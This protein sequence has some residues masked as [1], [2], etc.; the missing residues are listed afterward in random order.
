MYGT[1]HNPRF[2]GGAGNTPVITLNADYIQI[3]NFYLK[4]S[5]SPNGILYITTGHHDITLNNVAFGAGIRGINAVKMGTGGVVNL[6]VSHCWFFDIFD[7][8]KTGGNAGAGGAGDTA[9]GGGSHIQMNNCNGSGIEIANSKFYTKD[10]SGANNNNYGVGD[11]I[12]TFQCNGTAASR[13]WIHDNQIRGG[14]N[15]QV[16]GYIGITT[17][18]VGGSYQLVENNILVNPGQG[19]IG[20][21]PSGATFITIQNNRMYSKN[22]GNAFNYVGLTYNSVPGVANCIL[23]NNHITYYATAHAPNPYNKF[24]FQGPPAGWN[25]NTADTAVDPLA[26][27]IMLPNPLFNEFD[28]DLASTGLIFNPIQAKTYGNADFAPG[29]TSPNAITYTSSNTAVATIVG[30]NIH[31]VGAGTSTI[32]A[33]DGVTSIQ[34]LL[35]VNKA[36]L[37]VS[38]G[39][40]SKTYGAANPV[41]SATITGFVLG[42][43]SAVLTTQPTVST[44]ATIGSG[45]GSYPITASGATAANYSFSYVA[46]TLTI[47]KANLTI[48][49][50]NASRN[51]GSANPVFSASFSG[52]VNGDN[53]SALTAQPNITTPATI[54]SNAGTYSIV[55]AA[56]AANNYNINYVN[57]V[58]TVNKVSLVIT[59]NNV[60]RQFNTINPVLTANFS[61]FVNGDTAANLTTQPTISTTA[62]QSS[63]VG[64]Y[65]I[66][67]SGAASPNYNFAYV[68]GTMTVTAN[69]IIFGPIPT[70]TYGAADFGAGASSTT[71]IT[72]T[73]D[74]P[75]VATIVA[76]LVHIIG[77]GTANITA[78]N[79]STTASQPMTVNQAVVA[80]TPNNHTIQ[81]GAPIPLLDVTYSGFQ[82]GDTSSILTSVP[83]V[84]TTA[85][86]TSPLG[87][88]PITANGAVAQNYIFTYNSGV[89]SIIPVAGV[90][91]FSQP[92][93][94]LT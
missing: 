15:N 73:S 74:N 76:G 69:S 56:A 82:N 22:T 62:V 66:T 57:G 34:Q 60:T 53:S 11:I 81:L 9:H 42:Q 75:L 40:A 85:T 52:F 71:A 44:S 48:T 7:T 58:L 51:Y 12:S 25:T 46:G 59:A 90:I 24:A 6:V 84:S 14:S 1:G 68:P 30:G 94:V 41:L 3:S 20:V 72:Y 77:A 16:T 50:N 86:N 37:T 55:P 5:Q 43:T 78:N 79:G 21:M 8:L 19:G 23:Q 29:A 2:D 13:I 18:D 49:A 39:N 28:W 54:G 4:N 47:N 87:T 10:P 92:V 88:Y 31:I 35:T 91:H 32:T 27:E 61:G 33:N 17:G 89:L 93:I 45:V 67:A 38:T 26:T 64:T 70:K 65:P 63:P 80:V 83:V 36:P